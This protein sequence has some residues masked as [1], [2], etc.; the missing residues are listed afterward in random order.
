MHS[1]STAGRTLSHPV[2]VA[3][4]MILSLAC[5]GAMADWTLGAEHL[6]QASDVDLTVLGYSVPAFSYWNGDS[7]PDL[8]VGEGGGSTPGKVRIYLNS[9]TLGHPLFGDYFYA[10]SNG[11]ALSVPAS[12][13]LGAFPR[14]VQWDADGRKDLLVG[15]ADGRIKLYHNTNT[16]A[17]P[18]FDAG[19]YVQVGPVGNK[20]AI[21]VGARATVNVDDWNRDGKKDLV[22]G[23][24][25]G[26]VYVYVNEGTDTE[27]DFRASVFVQANGVNLT[28]ATGRSSPVM[29]DFDGD[30]KQDLLTGNTEAQLLLYRNLGTDAAPNFGNALAMTADGV[31]ID[32]LGS[33]RSRPFVCDWNNDGVNDVLIGAGDGKIHLYFGVPEPATL[34]LFGLAVLAV[35]RW[36]RTGR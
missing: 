27:P 31:P 14:T 19:D 13:C 35:S 33:V 9:G 30:G 10:Q 5:P 15:C 6:V 21:N 4:V 12:G 28:V 24:L 8:V 34:S 26:N 29:G 7:L 11:A 2:V 1:D 17:A 16:D 23:S 32:L 3:A 36:C 20:V 22:V 25:S 18:A